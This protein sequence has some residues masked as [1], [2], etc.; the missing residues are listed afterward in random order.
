VKGATFANGIVSLVFTN[1]TLA[2]IGN[3]AGLVGSSGVG[4]PGNLWVGLYTADPGPGGDQTTNETNYTAYARQSLPRSGAG[5]TVTAT[6]V[7]NAA[8]ITFPQCSG[9]TSTVTHFGVGTASAGAG[10][11]LYS[12]PLIT[13][14]YDCLGKQSTGVFTV[15]ANALM[16]NDAVELMLLP[17]GTFPGG[18]ALNTIY[19]VKTVS[20]NDITLAATAGGVALPVSSDGAC[21]IGRIGFLNVS[22]L[23]TP[24]IPA[25]SLVACIEY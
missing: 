16:V 15:P 19:F 12:G 5:W 7:A 25:G 3:A 1:T 13:T 22:N 17:N 10:L 4:S 24:Q 23:I 11:L 20:T 18:F 6:S 9:G 2:N 14:F 8:N 21:A